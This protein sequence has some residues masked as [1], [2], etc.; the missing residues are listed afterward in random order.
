ME[1][2]KEP[3][4]KAKVQIRSRLNSGTNFKQVRESEEN[5]S[6]FVLDWSF[7]FEWSSDCDSKPIKKEILTYI[8]RPRGEQSLHMCNNGSDVDWFST[9]ELTYDHWMWLQSRAETLMI[10]RMEMIKYSF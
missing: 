9:W 10:I 2:N 4:K 3:Y 7:S 5:L 8:T 6:P 1:K